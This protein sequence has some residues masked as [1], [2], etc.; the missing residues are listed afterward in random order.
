MGANFGGFTYAYLARSTA[1]NPFFGN[2]S[3][4]NALIPDYLAYIKQ[5]G[6]IGLTDVA[7]YGD[8][9]GRVLRETTV[10]SLGLLTIALAVSVAL[11]I[12][13]GLA[14]VRVRPPGVRT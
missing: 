11:G 12:G 2:Q 14:G 9:F 6:A 7:V 13:V 8:S 1:G 10:A 4:T 5:V 3:D